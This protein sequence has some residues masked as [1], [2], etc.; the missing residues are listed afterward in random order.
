VLLAF[1]PSISQ[2]ASQSTTSQVEF[3]PTTQKTMLCKTSSKF[4]YLQIH[5]MLL[6]QLCLM[7]QAL[8]KPTKQAED[9][10]NAEG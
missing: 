5:H 6:L 1:C 2:H 9:G 4:V 8:I 3:L 10:D 7:N